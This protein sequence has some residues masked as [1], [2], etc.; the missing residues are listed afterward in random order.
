M[1]KLI[2][3]LFVMLLAFTLAS[4]DKD[5]LSD[6][7][8][9]SKIENPK[10]LIDD[11]LNKDKDE[12][13]DGGEHV[14]TL[15]TVTILPTCSEVGRDVTTC[16]K[17]DFI[18]T[19]NYTDVIAHDYSEVL[20]FSSD[21]HWEA[22]KNCTARRNFRL[23]SVNEDT[24]CCDPCG[25]LLGTEKIKYMIDSDSSTATV[26]G[27]TGESTKVIIANSREGVPVTTIDL[28]AFEKCGHITEIVIPESVTTIFSSF[29]SCTNLSKI[30]VSE[31]NQN[32][33]SIDGNLYS[34][35]GKTLI[36]YASGKTETDFVI[37]DGVKSINAY[38]FHDC[39]NLKSVTIPDGATRIG[40]GAFKDCD[41][42]KS[43]AVPG[44][45][46]SIGNEAFYKCNSLRF[47]DIP[48]SVT[49]IGYSAFFDCSNLTS[50]VIPNSV[51][52]IDSYAFSWC[53][54]LTS[55][56][57]PNSVTSIVNDVF[58]RCSN[59]KDVYFTGSEEEWNAISIASGNE[60][61][62]NAT[63]HFNYVP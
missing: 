26:L 14:H 57:I 29:K 11:L 27:Y 2:L 31:Q 39:D 30:T 15:T 40:Y 35:D 59:L 44:S 58:Y 36:K 20:E 21:G 53:D 43:V 49:D 10:D 50:I 7:I 45:V 19:D 38:A 12:E 51:T 48:N 52:S 61:L 8:D 9:I 62:T 54:N 63:I 24:G 55:I 56:V 17:C 41:N 42:L 3:L 16:S 28:N 25:L 5:D 34:K 22:C 32:Y 13:T 1:K 6:K 23:H 60:Y 18:Q 4:C 47:V 37:P 46:T 33:K